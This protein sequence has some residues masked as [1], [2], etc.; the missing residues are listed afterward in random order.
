MTDHPSSTE[1]TIGAFEFKTALAQVGLGRYER[2][3]REH[4][5]S[6]WEN[7]AGITESDMAEM[8]FRLGD[9]RKLQRVI[10]EYTTSNTPKVPIGLQSLSP[11]VE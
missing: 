10:R 6:D 8:D 3:L 9:R 11:F 4:G 1:A 5:F 2:L 7:V